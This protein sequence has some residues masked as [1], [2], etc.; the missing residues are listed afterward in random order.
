MCIR[1]RMALGDVIS[2]KKLNSSLD[3]L[4][5]VLSCQP[6]PIPVKYL[7]HEAG[8][9]GNGIRLPLTWLKTKTV[10]IKQQIK[11]IKKEY[12]EL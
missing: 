12:S 7:L 1:D 2:A 11:H 3:S 4:F 6:N 8:L 9:I 10:E 5:K